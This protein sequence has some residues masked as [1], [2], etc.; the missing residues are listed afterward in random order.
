MSFLDDSCFGMGNEGFSDFFS[1]DIIDLEDFSTII[2]ISGDVR[3]MSLSFTNR[4]KIHTYIV[5]DDGNAVKNNIS[6]LTGAK[7]YDIA[8]NAL[9]YTKDQNLFKQRSLV[10]CALDLTTCLDLLDIKNM[11]KLYDFY[12]QGVATKKFNKTST[13]N[14]ILTAF[15]EEYKYKSVRSVFST[16]KKLTSKSILLVEK[17]TQYKIL[18]VSCLEFIRVK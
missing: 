4:H 15:I 7:M 17:Y 18:D 12:K 9:F 5:C 8:E 3:E 1:S 13:D 10:I 2:G 14:E 11:K 16:D 6:L